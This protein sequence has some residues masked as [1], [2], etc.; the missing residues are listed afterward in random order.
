VTMRTATKKPRAA[1]ALRIRT[2]SGIDLEQLKEYAALYST[3]EDAAALLDIDATALAALLED[4]GTPQARIWR[5]GRAG[6]R[7]N[8]RR[9]QF[10]QMEKNATLAI[11]LGKEILGQDGNGPAGPV[12]F[13]V[14][15]GIQRDEPET[16]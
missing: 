5:Q 7:L 9:A 14:D 2:G 13:V 4:A 6:A 11:Y 12:T 1:P 3:V 10:V 15:T 16:H 8:L